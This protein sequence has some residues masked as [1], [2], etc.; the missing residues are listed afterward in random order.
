MTSISI[1]QPGDLDIDLVQEWIGTMLREQGNDIFRMKGILSIAYSENKFVYQGVHM[2]FSGDFME[3]WGPQEKRE[4]RIVFI[5]RNLNKEGMEAAFKNC[6]MTP[7]HQAKKLK[8]LRFQ[9]GAKVLC[10]TND[11]WE[12]GTV[13]KRMYR[14]DGM[15]PG[16]VAPYQVKLNDGSLI[17]A[18]MDTKDVIRAA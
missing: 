13:I 15:P 18:P 4:S 14:D 16:M 3:E 11:G 9:V 1:V 7:E 10:N 6:I 12:K 8:K 2:I 17:Y 5:G